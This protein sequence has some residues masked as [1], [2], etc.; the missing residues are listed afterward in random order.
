MYQDD[1]LILQISS[2]LRDDG[3]ISKITG[4]TSLVEHLLPTSWTRTAVS[5][6]FGFCRYQPSRRSEKDYEDCRLTA[7]AQSETSMKPCRLVR[8]RKR[9][10][11]TSNV[12]IARN[13]ARTDPSRAWPFAFEPLRRT[14]DCGGNYAEVGF[15][16]WS[17][18]PPARGGNEVCM[19]VTPARGG[20]SRISL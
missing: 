19:Y 2:R 15:S 20:F 11:T 5:D 3:S 13:F 6:T 7:K 1:P 16:L 8:L 9:L 18:S 10:T 4:R 14:I 17:A 12:R